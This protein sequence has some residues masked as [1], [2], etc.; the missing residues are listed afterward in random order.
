MHDVWII[1]YYYV[2][3]ILD[4]CEILFVLTIDSEKISRCYYRD[5]ARKSQRY[6]DVYLGRSV[7][8]SP[9]V[10][11]ERFPEPCRLVAPPDPSPIHLGLDC[12]LTRNFFLL[13]PD[14]KPASRLRGQ[15]GMTREIKAGRKEHGVSFFTADLTKLGHAMESICQSS[16][17]VSIRYSGSIRTVRSCKPKLISCHLSDGTSGEGTRNAR[18]L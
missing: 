6:V 15:C 14:R 11:G 7:P 4:V 12:F 8:R 17:P 1:S 2:C 13:H 10:G 3:Y 16:R 18:V 5:V 9:V